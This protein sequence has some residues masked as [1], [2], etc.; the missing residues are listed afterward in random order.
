MTRKFRMLALSMLL[1][2]TISVSSV[3]AWTGSSSTAL[4]ADPAWSAVTIADE[5]LINSEFEIPARTVSIGTGNPVDADAVLIF[6]DGSATSVETVLLDMAGQYTVRYTAVINNMP[7]VEEESFSVNQV[8]AVINTD[9]GDDVSGFHWGGYEHALPTTEGLVVTLIEGASIT[10]NQIIDMNT[11][12]KDTSIFRGFAMPENKGS[13]DFEKI[14]L[15]FTDIEDPSCYLRA[16]VS[17]YYNG[18][19]YRNSYWKVGSNEQPLVGWEEYWKRL[20]VDNEWGTPQMH[21]FSLLFNP[22]EEKRPDEMQL[23]FRWDAPTL[24]AY[25]SSTMIVDLDN[26]AYFATLWKGFKSGKCRLTINADMYTNGSA[27]FCITEL[28]GIDYRVHEN[29]NKFED[30]EAPEIRVDLKDKYVGNMPNAKIGGTYKVPAATGYDTIDKEVAVKSAVYYNYNTLNPINVNVNADGTFATAAAGVYAVVYTAKDLAGNETKRELIIEATPNVAPITLTVPTADRITSLVCGQYISR[31]NTATATGGSGDIDVTVTAT[32]GNDIYDITNGK[33]LIEK[34]GTY[35]VTYKAVDYIG[36]TAEVSYDIV[37]TRGTAP[38]A[39]EEPYLPKY[40]F[41]GYAQSIEPYYFYDYTSGTKQT[42]LATVKVNGQTVAAG[43]TFTPDAPATN[44]ATIPVEFSYTGAQSIVYNVPVV[45]SVGVG[46]KKT[47]FMFNYIV[48]DQ[49]AV[50]S[51]S[52]A[53]ISLKKGKTATIGWA[54]QLVAQDVALTLAFVGS[55]ANFDKITFTLADARYPNDLDRQVS[56]DLVVKGNSLDLIVGEQFIGLDIS[57]SASEALTIGYA[58]GCI[59]Y[60]NS[61]LNVPH[62]VSGNEFKGFSGDMVYATFTFHNVGDA[63]Q[64]KLT[65]IGNQPISSVLQDLV[66]PNWTAL[67]D[68]G[69]SFAQGKTVTIPA[70]A[71]S[72]IIAPSVTGTLTVKTPGSKIA[73]DAK[74]GQSLENVSPYQA[75]SIK[76]EEFGA[77]SVTLTLSDGSKQTQ[78]TFSIYTVDRVKPVFRFNHYFKTSAKVGDT[79]TIPNFTVSDNKSATANIIVTTYVYTPNG[80]LLVLKDSHNK[81]ENSSVINKNSVKCTIPGTYEFRLFAEDEAGNLAYVRK[82]FTVTA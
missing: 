14:V 36:Q 69:G 72:D 38:I 75:Y 7:Y 27:T 50:T 71:A 39:V 22:G 19:T 59:V 63:A 9:E 43:Q 62:A 1:A 31:I 16:A 49:T 65:Q 28:N 57:I 79:V 17:H 2:L 8:A 29:G 47:N 5:Y 60:G 67:G 11:L 52:G 12:T 48:G 25:T 70:F 44:L 13:V 10:F 20:H 51:D 41:S 40:F 18:Y 56:A 82:A 23:D 26:P 32:C 24:T 45:H 78:G 66:G 81:D 54:N 68:Y 4:G 76:L 30:T 37:V 80:E 35:T 64:I 58:D 53:K 15:T 33:V 74:T 46:G 73:K 61:K 42:R 34:E 6:P 21:S 3:S 55:N 77:Y